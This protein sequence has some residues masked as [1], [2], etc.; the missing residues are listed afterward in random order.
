MEKRFEI[1][2][3]EGFL[4]GTRIIVDT[5]TGV[6]YLYVY[7]GYGGGVTPLLDRDGKPLIDKRFG[8]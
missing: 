6:Q 7:S 5:E 1:L 4:E 3:K 2:E 8:R